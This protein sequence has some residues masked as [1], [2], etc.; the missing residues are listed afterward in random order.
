MTQQ[1]I[2]I[3]DGGTELGFIRCKVLLKYSELIQLSLTHKNDFDG[4][5]ITSVDIK[6]I[7]L[8]D[9]IFKG[10]IFEKC[11]FEWEDVLDIINAQKIYIKF[12]H[13]SGATKEVLTNMIVV[14][15]MSHYFG[16]NELVKFCEIIL[17][18]FKT[19]EDLIFVDAK[20][21]C[22][23]DDGYG[24]G[25]DTDCYR[26]YGYI[27]ESVIEEISY[28]KGLSY[29]SENEKC[30]E[31][32]YGPQ[33]TTKCVLT[34]IKP[35]CLQICKFIIDKQNSFYDISELYEFIGYSDDSDDSDDSDEL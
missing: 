28:Y 19:K 23:N 18:E 4:K 30:I 25:D 21:E 27:K 32:G 14:K 7:Q 13:V 22:H 9:N 8:H 20:C 10:Y 3:T 11:S 17:F 15:A 33:P 1:D 5:L 34:K 16:M 24:S 6:D 12:F 35:T 2:I 31:I 29:F 26:Y